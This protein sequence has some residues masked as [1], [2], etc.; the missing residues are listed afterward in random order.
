MDQVCLGAAVSPQPS[1]RAPPSWG[2]KP[3]NSGCKR[4]S[5]ADQVLPCCP[6]HFQEH[7]RPGSA[8][9]THLLPSWP[10]AWSQQL[11]SPPP[12]SPSPG[13]GVVHLC[14]APFPQS[15]NMPR[16]IYHDLEETLTLPSL[17][18]L[19]LPCSTVWL[20]REPWATD[21]A[22]FKQHQWNCVLTL[23]GKWGLG[24]WRPW[25]EELPHCLEQSLRILSLKE[26]STW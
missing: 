25:G 12:A 5:K 1:P 6:P 16:Q 20:L 23:Q 19:P 10:D 24:P 7:P 9:S 18:L 26:I 22:L 21:S 11:L 13:P 17:K 14:S 15:A 4:L 3:R 8:V 2:H